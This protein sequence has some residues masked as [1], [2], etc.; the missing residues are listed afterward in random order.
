[1]SG[2]CAVDPRPVP[3]SSETHDYAPSSETEL[4]DESNPATGQAKRDAP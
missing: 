1:M 4:E 3:K 2:S